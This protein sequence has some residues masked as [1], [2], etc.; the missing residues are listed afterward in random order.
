VVPN[1]ILVVSDNVFLARAFDTIVE[2]LGLKR[3]HEFD[4]ACSPG[5]VLLGAELPFTPIEMRVRD[6]VTEIVRKYHLVISA[7]CKQLFPQEMVRAVRCVNIHPGFNPYNRGW[8][9]QVF[10]ILNRKP[11]GATIHEIDEELDHGPI[12]ARLEVP[13]H[14]WDTSDTAYRR[15]LDAELGLVREWIERIV[16]R[17]YSTVRAESEG[18]LNLKRDFDA[19]CRL[20]LSASGSLGEHI[21]LL[22]ALTHEHYG[23]GFFVDPETGKRVFVSIALKPEQ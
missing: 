23:N 8:F 22:R 13:L 20:D 5:S 7:H 9:P 12:I 21:D 10:S 1:S 11:L 15:V 19:L 3:E 6:C 14:R 16:N 2:E 17:V 18:N 4:Y